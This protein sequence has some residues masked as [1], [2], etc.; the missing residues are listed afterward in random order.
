MRIQD[1]FTGPCACS[2]PKTQ[3]QA[4]LVND[5]AAFVP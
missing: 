5:L 3:V 2:V 4:L 1:V